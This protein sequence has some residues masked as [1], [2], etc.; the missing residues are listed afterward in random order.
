VGIGVVVVL[1]VSAGLWGTVTSIR[2]V[3]AYERS[4]RVTNAI[5]QARYALAL[6]RSAFRDPQLNRGR[7]EFFSAAAA[8]RHDVRLARAAG[9][10]DD[11]VPAA[12]LLRQQEELVLGAGL[13]FGAHAAGNG[14]RV[15]TLVRETVEPEVVRLNAAL[16]RSLTE[17]RGES[18]TSWPSAPVQKLA[19]AAAMLLVA[20]GL[21]SAA[22]FLMRLVGERRRQERARREALARLEEQALRDNLTGLGNHRAFYE[23]LKRAIT[24]RT[25]T[26]IGFSIVMLDLDRLK[27]INDTLGHQAGDERIRAVAAALK[28]TV[29]GSDGGYRTGGDEFMA[30]LPGERAWG[31]LTFAQ[32]LQAEIGWRGDGLGVSCG[33]VESAALESA[34]TL[35]RRADIALYEAK[36][37]GRRVVIYSDGL[38]PKPTDRPE[39]VASRRHHRLLA[40]AL[41][42][43]VDAKDVGTRDHCET[44]SALCVLI[45]QGLGLEG[46]RLEQLRLAGLL[47]DVG[48][49]GIPDIVLQKPVALD[50]DER[51]AMSGHV[52]IGHAIVVAAGLE[53]EADWILH[54][55]EHFD[56]SGYPEGLE[57]S[58]IPLESRI[59]LVADAFEA[60]TADR[61]YRGARQPSEAFRELETG[62]GTQFDPAC[63]EALRSVLDAGHA[64]LV[65]GDPAVPARVATVDAAP[66]SAP[67][68]EPQV[69]ST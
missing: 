33:I 62:A 48:K 59:I 14:Q 9:A 26:G 39:D 58:G 6:E 23:D 3:Q 29:R 21:A 1:I 63:V 20:L 27:E 52:S 36:H 50:T 44:V 54:H 42:Q 67:S 35:V 37:T 2:G 45:G 46:E 22:I 17:I 64:T 8:F 40:T 68:I 34:D 57:G 19:L 11:I 38:R 15:Q 43:A 7:Q 25:R 55:H 65:V 18:A 56:G 66:T 31:A 51:Q 24:R 12:Q 47:H 30:L 28:A 16:A 32:R 5:E 13:L 10:R 69:L 49:I 60:M 41:A 61:P 4:N 53:E